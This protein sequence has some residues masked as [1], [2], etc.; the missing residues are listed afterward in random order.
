[1]RRSYAIDEWHIRSDDDGRTVEGKIVPYNEPAKVMERDR[2]TGEI[3]T[4]YEQFLPRSCMAMAQGV[5]ARGNAAF[6]SFLMEHNERDLDAK[7]GYAATLEDKEDG[8]YAMFR[9]YG[10]RD[11][12]KVAS[13]LAES[14]RG[15]SVN[16]VDTK[17]P[18][19]IDGIV[20]RV[21]VHIDHVAATPMPV[22]SSAAISGMRSED[23]GLLVPETP[24]LD[25]VRAW[26]AE[27]TKA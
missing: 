18:R 10:G 6:I 9:L 22:Y 4:F 15:L 14:H 24:A 5:K 2:T 3:K 7:I 25:D 21:Q 8:A 17:P 23:G 26:L 27:L 20:S 19:V 11:L 12:E 16:F 13:M 1:M